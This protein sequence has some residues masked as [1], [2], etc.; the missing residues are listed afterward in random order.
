MKKCETCGKK[1]ADTQFEKNDK[2]YFRKIC[3]NCSNAER[4]KYRS[5]SPEYFIR[6]LYSQL[7][8][9]RGKKNPEMEW[10]I[11]PEDLLSLYQEQ[12][13]RCALS[14]VLMTYAKDGTG[15]KEFNI[16]IDRVNPH[17][18]YIA[19]N[20]Q[21]VCHRVNIMKHT[22]MEEDFWWWC[23]IIVETQDEQ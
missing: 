19:S 11:E 13:G 4:N 18:G 10:H 5:K 2:K 23:K 22:L 9:S 12:N 8:Y 20:M 6:H 16:S 14:N 1:L 7:K 3:K 15:K 21:L 17:K